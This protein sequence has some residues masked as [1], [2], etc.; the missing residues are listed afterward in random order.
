MSHKIDVFD[1]S[2]YNA[3]YILIYELVIYINSRLCH[4]ITF[5]HC[6]VCL[7]LRFT[8]NDYPF[9]IIKLFLNTLLTFHNPCRA[10]P[11]VYSAYMLYT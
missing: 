5:D 3:A 4:T 1:N 6:I 7:F 10:C 9:V 8:Y 2:Y 11:F